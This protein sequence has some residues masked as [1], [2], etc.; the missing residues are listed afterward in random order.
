MLVML[1]STKYK[2]KQVID[3]AASSNLNIQFL[4]F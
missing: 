1:I 3:S 4:V 2:V